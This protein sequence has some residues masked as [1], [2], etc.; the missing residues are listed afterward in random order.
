[1]C[2]QGVNFSRESAICKLLGS[3]TLCRVVD[4]AVQIHGGMGYMADYPIERM[5]RDAR[6]TRIFEGTNEIQRLV[7]AGDL[8]KKG[9]Y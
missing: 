3:E 5:F 9:K 6:I 8:A 1:M 2:D 4:S 7:V